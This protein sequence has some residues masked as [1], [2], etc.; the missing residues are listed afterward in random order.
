MINNGVHWASDF[1]LGFA[2]G[3][4]Y[5]KYI[6]KKNKIKVKATAW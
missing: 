2:L 6:A 3:Y 1:P 4:G 5:G